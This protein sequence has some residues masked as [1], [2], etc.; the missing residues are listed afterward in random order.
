MI[1]GIYPF[2]ALCGG[3]NGKNGSQVT[4]LL[5]KELM[6]VMVFNGYWK[7]DG[8]DLNDQNY[9]IVIKIIS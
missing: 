3:D 6:I 7:D 1:N 5:M 8:R 9:R 2:R 4:L